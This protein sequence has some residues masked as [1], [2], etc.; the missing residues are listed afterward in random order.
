[1]YAKNSKLADKFLENALLE[2]L[3]HLQVALQIEWAGGG[4]NSAVAFHEQHDSQCQ[5]VLYTHESYC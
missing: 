3:E 2:S 5:Y 1:M 4:T